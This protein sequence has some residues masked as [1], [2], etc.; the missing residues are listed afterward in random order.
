MSF[1]HISSQISCNSGEIYLFYCIFKRTISISVQFHPLI[2]SPPSP[3]HLPPSNTANPHPGPV[4]DHYPCEDIDSQPIGPH[5]ARPVSPNGG[6]R[7]Q[8][9]GTDGVIRSKVFKGLDRVQVR[10][11][12]AKEKEGAKEEVGK[13]GEEEEGVK[14]GE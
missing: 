10:R 6:L 7:I 3:L 11:E 1:L 5:E 9:I 4:L 13:E 8:F 12:V 2:S 14:E